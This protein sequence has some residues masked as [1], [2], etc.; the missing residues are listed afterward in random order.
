MWVNPIHAAKTSSPDGRKVFVVVGYTG[1]FSDF[2]QWT[3]A[4][5]TNEEDAKRHVLLADG[6]AREHKIWYDVDDANC[7][8]NSGLVNPFDPD[9]MLDHTGVRYTYVAAPLFE[10]FADV[11]ADA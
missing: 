8:M 11:A 6:Y 7:F 3:V 1:E 5:Y 9:M 10:A 4:A 2:N